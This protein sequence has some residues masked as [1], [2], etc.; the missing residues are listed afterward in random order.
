M[1]TWIFYNCPGKPIAKNLSVSF[2]DGISIPG[3]NLHDEVLG[4]VGYGLAGQ[5]AHRRQTRR[6]GKFLFLGITH[7]GERRASL[8][9]DAMTGGASGN[10]TTGMI[11]VN[12]MSK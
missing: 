10:A 11:D 5:A 3:G 7:F 12:A 9:H 4:A 2:A 8:F 1:R 6:I